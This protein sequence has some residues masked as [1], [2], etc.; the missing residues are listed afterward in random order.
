MTKRVYIDKILKPIV[1]EWAKEP[2]RWSLEEDGDS[3]HGTNNS[4]DEVERF[5]RSIGMT[6]DQHGWHTSYFNKSGSPD[7]SIIEDC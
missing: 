3:G 4:K 2:C 7:L 5:K 1:S 6:R